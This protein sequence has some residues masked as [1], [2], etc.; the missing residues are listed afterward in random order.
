SFQPCEQGAKRVGICSVGVAFPLITVRCWSVT[1]TLLTMKLPWSNRRICTAFRPSKVIRLPPSMTVSTFVGKFIV[2]VIGMVTGTEPQ[3]KVITPP[4]LTAVFSAANVQLA[5][6][7]VPMTAVGLATLAG[8]APA[9]SAL[10][11]WVGMVVVPPP[12]DDPPALLP[13]VSLPPVPL[14]PPR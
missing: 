9:G 1:R 11:Q 10:V 4:R 12:P 7:P 2:D 5:A 8:C 14:D 3:L 13:P 6:V